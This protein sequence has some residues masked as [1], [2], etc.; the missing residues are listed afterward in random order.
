[1]RKFLPA[2]TTN[3]VAQWVQKGEHNQQAHD[4]QAFSESYRRRRTARQLAPSKKSHNE[5]Y[6]HCCVFVHVCKCWQCGWRSAGTVYTGLLHG[7]HP[8]LC[9]TFLATLG[10]SWRKRKRTPPADP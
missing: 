9:V 10:L 8:A 4:L 7:G 5:P 6:S 3:D 1:M 2:V